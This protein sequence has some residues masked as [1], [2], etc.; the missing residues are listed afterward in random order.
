MK[1]I[2]F[3]ILILLFAV[4]AHALNLAGQ[5]L[6]SSG[7]FVPS[8]PTGV[9]AVSGD[10]K[11]TVSWSA[12]TG[13]TSYDLYKKATD[14]MAGDCV[15]NGTKVTGVTSPYDITGLTNGVIEYAMVKACASG[16]CSA[17]SSEVSATPAAAECTGYLICQNFEGTGYD[18]SESWTEVIN[19]DAVI[20]ED[21]A[22][23]PAPLRGSQSLYMN[24]GTYTGTT[25]Y[26]YFTL[27]PT[28]DTVYTRF[29]FKPVSYP[30][31][32]SNITAILSTGSSVKVA[33]EYV[34]DNTFKFAVSDGATNTYS[35]DV[36]NF[37][38]H[39][40]TIWFQVSKGTG[41]NGILKMY[42][43]VD[44][45]TKPETAAISVTNAANTNAISVVYPYINAWGTTKTVQAI[46]DQ[47]LVKTTEIGSGDVP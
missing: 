22:T 47:I 32:V 1:K 14:S 36:S 43:A 34:S 5:A 23:S 38:D 21:Y 24:T 40:Y 28:Q 30:A 12:S 44:S 10:T 15:A 37:H 17:C 19:G 7:G 41:A 20:N 46:Y 25:F 31:N 13:A 33:V 2:L 27:S 29:I 6:A 45:T 16:G 8:A 18:N 9:T 26:T 3:T 42:Y 39:Q 35:S 4:N 11:I